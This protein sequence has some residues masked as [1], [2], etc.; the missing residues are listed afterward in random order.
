MKLVE[1]LFP[2]TY[3]RFDILRPREQSEAERG[4]T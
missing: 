4:D 2:R 1:D 3:G